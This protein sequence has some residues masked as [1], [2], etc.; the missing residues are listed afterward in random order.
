MKKTKLPEWITN[1]YGANKEQI[2]SIRNHYDKLGFKNTNFF[3]IA[4]IVA[5]AA[6]L[7]TCFFV[8]SCFDFLF[9]LIYL[10]AV[11]VFH[12]FLFMFLMS[13][14]AVVT[15]LLELLFEAIFKKRKFAYVLSFLMSI[16]L[17]FFLMLLVFMNYEG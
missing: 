3:I 11:I 13:G 10:L 8:L 12:P 4:A 14:G 17:T 1:Y 7:I 15:W 6:F 9:A 5:Y 2:E 16:A